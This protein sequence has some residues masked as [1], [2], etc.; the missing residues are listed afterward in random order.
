MSTSAAQRVLVLHAPSLAPQAF[1]SRRYTP[2]RAPIPAL[3]PLIHQHFAGLLALDAIGETETVFPYTITNKYYTSSI[4]FLCLPFDAPELALQQNVPVVL[5]LFSGPQPDPLPPYL[6]KFL[7][8]TSP[9]I[10]LAIRLA[11]AREVELEEKGDVNVEAFDELG[12]EFVD[13]AKVAEEEDDDDERRKLLRLLDR[14]LSPPADDPTAIGAIET[15][16]QTIQTHMWPD[17]IRLPVSAYREPEEY[18]PSTSFPITFNGNDEPGDDLDLADFPGLEEL[19]ASLA[20]EDKER[21]ERIHRLEAM[22]GDNEEEEEAEDD[23]GAMVN[24]DEY[25]RLEEW[26]D[27]GDEPTPVRP[28]E[29][30]EPPGE[31]ADSRLDMG[32]SDPRGPPETSLSFDDDFS[33]FAEFQSASSAPYEDVEPHQPL[34]PL[35]PTPLLLHLQAVRAELAG[36]EDE[37]ERRVRA[38]REVEN[39]MRGLGF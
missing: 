20:L 1:L 36:L 3:V 19:K 15:I 34:L 2:R 30:P 32:L 35:D 21:D 24:Q 25:E 16:L 13:E 22:W 23:A 10:A 5:Y 39:V 37:D 11:E 7:M 6:V 12:M 31:Q 14:S 9:D 18:T 38:G 33:D 27:E 26:L 28:D 4:H 8:D 29:K 17:M